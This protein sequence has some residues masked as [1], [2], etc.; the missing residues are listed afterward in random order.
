[1]KRVWKWVIGIVIVLVVVA[2]VVGGVFLLSHRLASIGGIARL[3]RPGVQVPGPQNV[4]PGSPRQYP[5]M[6]PFG[7]YGFGGPGMYMRGRGMM[8]FGGFNI[9]GGIIRGLFTLGILAL[10]VLGI[11]WLVSYVRR[12]RTYAAAVVPASPVSS[13]AP[14]AAPV[15]THPCPQC[16]E[17]VQDNWKHCPNCGTTL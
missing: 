1:M 7:N 2:A 3:T 9:V 15:A 10:V 16:G 17:L 8:G 13:V 4:Q 12:P 11:I 5:G 6:R 14:A